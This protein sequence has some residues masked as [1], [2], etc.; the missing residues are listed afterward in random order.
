MS[1]AHT[2]MYVCTLAHWDA[3]HC[4]MTPLRDFVV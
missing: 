3:L 1:G 4:T 2:C